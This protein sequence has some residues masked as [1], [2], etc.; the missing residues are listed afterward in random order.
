[1]AKSLVHTRKTKIA[2]PS[3]EAILARPQFSSSAPISVSHPKLCK[4]WHSQKNFFTPDDYTYGSGEKVWWICK[5]GPDHVWKTAISERTLGGTGCPFCDGKKVS[6]TNSLQTL[7]PKVAKQLHP[8]KNG[9]ITAKDITARSDRSFWWQCERN[10]DHIWKTRVAN[11]TSLLTGC[12]YCAGKIT[13][14]ETSLRNTHPELAKDWHKEKN[15]ILKSSD[16]SAQSNKR[17]WWRCKEGPDHEWQTKVQDRVNNNS[18]CP[19]CAGKRVCST[20]SLAALFPQIAREW[21]PVR[22]EKLTA[23][24]VTR[25]SFKRA[26]WRCSKDP[27]HEWETLVYSRGVKNTGCPFCRNQKVCKSNSLATV[28]PEIAKEWHP[29]KNKKLTPNDVT[30]GSSKKVWWRCSR[31]A[32]HEWQAAV[33]SRGLNGTGCPYC[34]GKIACKTNS[35]AVL[36]PELAL[37]WHKT[38]NGKLTAH[39]VVPGSSKRAWWHCSKNRNHE[40]EVAIYARGVGKNGCPH[41]RRSRV[42][43]K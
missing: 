3:L 25:G 32:S 42:A 26:W 9:K 4:E 38:K 29:T 12:P 2:G 36:C 14:K 17:V 39:D 8:R 18:G 22:N 24:D 33:A 1:M 41:C 23:N 35:L 7:F 15:G 16:V 37:E 21:H 13:T 10:S 5:K 20:N 28:M 43:K 40:W 19:F 31:H 6:V 34:A 30:H 11:R 27:S